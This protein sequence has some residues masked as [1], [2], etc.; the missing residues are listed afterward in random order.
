MSR[1]RGA[2]LLGAAAA[3]VL[4][5]LVLVPTASAATQ[6]EINQAVADGAAWIRT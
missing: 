4:G 5:V 1:G 6:A 3:A 2:L